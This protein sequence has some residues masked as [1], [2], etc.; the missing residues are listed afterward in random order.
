MPFRQFEGFFIAQYSVYNQKGVP[1]EPAQ[2]AKGKIII[3]AATRGEALEKL[4]K[5]FQDKG[6]V[7]AKAS[8]EAIWVL[9]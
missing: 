7:V 9:H 1:C 6:L 5:Y 3:Q 8:I 2:E 4:Q